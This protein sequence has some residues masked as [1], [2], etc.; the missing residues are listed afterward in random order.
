VDIIPID[1][2]T[3]TSSPLDC[4]R[5]I[6]SSPL[7][8]GLPWKHLR[9][10]RRNLS[11]VLALSVILGS[12]K[13]H[14]LFA[15]F[16]AEDTFP[17]IDSLSD[18]LLVSDRYLGRTRIVLSSTK[19][20][21]CDFAP[22]QSAVLAPK[23][24]GILSL[25]ALIRAKALRRDFAAV[26]PEQ[27]FWIQP[28]DRVRTIVQTLNATGT[29]GAQHDR[30]VEEALR[31][32]DEQFNIVEAATLHYAAQ[33]GL[34]TES[35]RDP[36]APYKVEIKI[37]PPGARVRFMPLLCFIRSK[38]LNTPLDEQWI[39]LQEGTQHLIGKYR[40]LAEWPRELSGP[41]EGTFEVREDSVITFTPAKR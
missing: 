28:L 9:L 20:L 21:H 12:A 4:L 25:E 34:E 29:E 38:K 6:E 26:F 24:P 37:Q 8:F 40:Y 1:T 2:L 41:V 22:D 33:N 11:A 31:Q 16:Y 19:M 27:T 36:A 23:N 14:T 32:I 17:V 7:E 39:D 3:I 35:A 10:K 5:G 30:S 13:G 15:N 18:Q